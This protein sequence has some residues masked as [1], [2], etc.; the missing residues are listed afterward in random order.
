MLI[1]H[2]TCYWGYHTWQSELTRRVLKVFKREI[3][4]NLLKRSSTTF[5]KQLAPI[6]TIDTIPTD[7]L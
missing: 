1:I 4:L 3:A 5:I 7:A 2:S 6:A